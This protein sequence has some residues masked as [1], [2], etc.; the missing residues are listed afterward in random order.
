MTT[1]SFPALLQ[2]YFTDRLLGQLG[3]SRHTVACY[4]DT[5]RL[6]LRF[7]A[8]HLRRSPSDL[9]V[10]DLDAAFLTQFLDHV[11]H[12]R[13]CSARTRNVR[14]SALHA[15]FRYVTLE[16]PQYALHCQ[17]VL[18]I[19]A[20][21]FER[22]PVEFLVEEEIAALIATPDS[23]TWLGRR[24]RALLLV[25][26]W[27][28]LR[29]GELTAM[30][31]VD[32]TLGTGANVRCH[33][34][35]RKTRCTP[36]HPDVTPILESWLHEQDLDPATPVFP[37]SRGG[38]LSSDALQRLVHKHVSAAAE[39][40]PS[41]AERQITPHT[42]R[43]STAMQMLRRGVDR[44][45]IAL[46]LGHESMETTQIYLHADMQLKEQALAHATSSGLSP[47]R[48][49]PDDSLLAFLDGL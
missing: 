36:L 42:L 35:G 19:P 21:R 13:G 8:Q 3:A 31:R 20:K 48:Y 49:Q 25:A 45:V 27:T 4:R 43:H 40:C 39:R 11:E 30:R 24:D 16:E 38:H 44:S 1:A 33:G 28:G 15:F 9:R 46:W 37:S 29:N 32:V 17:R 10:G 47:G 14:L 22:R 12:T 41:L 6:L 2:R 18:A 5:F 7:A 26:V 34:K 23:T